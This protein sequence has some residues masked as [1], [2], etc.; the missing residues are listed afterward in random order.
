MYLFILRC[1]D[2]PVIREACLVKLSRINI[3]EMCFPS[4]SVAESGMVEASTGFPVRQGV[5]GKLRAIK[6]DNSA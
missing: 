2:V 5:T 3:D 6:G 1:V 4:S